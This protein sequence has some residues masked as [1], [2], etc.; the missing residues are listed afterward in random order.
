MKDMLVKALIIVNLKIISPHRHIDHI[1][2][3]L[4]YGDKFFIAEVYYVHYVS[5]WY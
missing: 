4:N 3:E 1:A 5:M 2:V